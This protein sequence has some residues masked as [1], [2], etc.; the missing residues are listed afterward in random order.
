MKGYVV[1]SSSFKLRSS[2]HSQIIPEE[3]IL[4]QSI[5]KNPALKALV[6][7]SH[8]H[9]YLC[10]MVDVRPNNFLLPLRD[11]A[12]GSYCHRL[13]FMTYETSGKVIK[14]IIQR[15]NALTQR[16]LNQSLVDPVSLSANSFHFSASS[17][18]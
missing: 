12:E 4:L 8:F 13:P 9:D 10:E 6:E 1:F 15:I 11:S 7:A 5:L 18:W 2:L 14:Q 17:A 16:A 3:D